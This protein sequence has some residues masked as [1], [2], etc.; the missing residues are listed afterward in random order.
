[1]KNFALFALTCLFAA[2]ASGAPRGIVRHRDGVPGIYIVVLA[3]KPAPAAVPGIARSLAASYDL[4]ILNLFPYAPHGFLASGNESSVTA[5]SEDPRVAYVEQDAVT[6]APSSR[7]S[8]R[9]WFPSR[10]DLWYLDRLDDDTWSEHNHTY[11]MCPEGGSVTA[12]VIDSGIFEH[13][14]FANNSGSSIQQQLNFVRHEI[15]TNDPYPA[16]DSSNGCAGF[17]EGYH[18]TAVASLLA[19]N[20]HGAS[21]AKLVSLRIIGCASNSAFTSDLL[22]ALNWLGARS[23]ATSGVVNLSYFVPPYDPQFYAVG[24]A[25][26]DVVN[27]TQMP[28]FTSAD[29][30]STDSCTLFSPNHRGYNPINRRDGVAMVV[31][32]SMILANTDYRWQEYNGSAASPMIGPGSGSNAGDCVGVYAPAHNV[33]FALNEPSASQPQYATGSGTSFA[34]ALAAGVAARY[35]EWFTATR[36]RK[37]TA[38][39]VY[40]FISTADDSGIISTQPSLNGNAVLDTGMPTYSWCFREG[41]NGNFFDLSPSQCS[42]ENSTDHIYDMLPPTGYFQ[43][44]MLHWSWPEPS[45]FC[46]DSFDW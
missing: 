8:A 41:G 15:P 23:V 36:G 10:D 2:Y 12:Y 25:I 27:Q 38:E 45:E 37:P 30:Y 39:E 6:R 21:Y 22:G 31:G 20:V 3:D 18:G 34:S 33:T 44:R 17:P 19:G 24:D 11:S 14:E 7:L 42:L 32:G 16:S 46:D 9:R 40:Y 4:S 43:A 35:V 29:N 5:L 13:Q 1:M 28:V 26:R